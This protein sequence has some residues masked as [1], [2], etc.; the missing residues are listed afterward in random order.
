MTFVDSWKKSRGS[1]FSPYLHFSKIF[2]WNAQEIGQFDGFLFNFLLSQI[3]V[4]F[5]GM[6]PLASSTL[7][8]Y[9]EVGFGILI[10]FVLMIWSI[11]NNYFE[12]FKKL[13]K[14]LT[15]KFVVVVDPQYFNAAKS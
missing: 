15:G 12:S 7:R 10:L 14:I 1:L 13:L 6:A 8:R 9:I 4:L 11:I 5:K 2:N 3:P